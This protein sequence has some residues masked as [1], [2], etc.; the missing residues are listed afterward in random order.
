MSE[1][2]SFLYPVR[3][4]IFCQPYMSICNI[5][6]FL[7]TVLCLPPFNWVYRS[8]R[9][10]QN[11]NGVATSVGFKQV[12][13]TITGDKSWPCYIVRNAKVCNSM[14]T[15]SG[16]SFPVKRECNYTKNNW[17][18]TIIIN[19]LIK[20]M[21]CHVST[22]HHFFWPDWDIKISSTR[23][24][25]PSPF[26]VSSNLLTFKFFWFHCNL[27]ETFSISELI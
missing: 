4:N 21:W 16:L 6:M 10:G 12:S 18:M 8:W 5:F 14:H 2:C 1:D 13:L 17:I 23:Y 20:A 26:V 11:L 3:K 22:W 9:D 19:S 15:F 27:S 25:L 7:F 24:W